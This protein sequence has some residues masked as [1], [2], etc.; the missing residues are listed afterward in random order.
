MKKSEPTGFQVTFLLFAV[1][2]AAM[3]ITSWAAKQIDLPED[4]FNVLGN[5]L[6]FPLEI[7][8][9]LAFA[10]IRGLVVE[11]LSVPLSLHAGK[12]AA[13]V[14]ALK[15][16]ITFGVWG[17]V[18]LWGIHVMEHPELRAYGFLT[19]RDAMDAS[20]LS[21]WGITK[22]LYAVSLGPIIEEILYRGVL[23]RLWERQWGWIA[24]AVLSAAVF[25]II[26]PH[27]LI[28]TFLSA[29]LYA[30]VY[31]R[32]GTLWAPILCHILF[33]LSVTWPLLG[34]V[35]ILKP[36]EAATTFAPWIPNVA[37]LAIGIPG[38][39]YYLWLTART[40]VPR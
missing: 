8:I 27:N 33:N 36:A 40:P 16:T 5:L 11:G 24:G 34:Q 28:V 39:L 17:A 9:V 13:G 31:R 3:L 25:S 1:A 2:F 38:F 12:E 7:G 4:R 18:A 23:Y 26:H 29:I 14:A 10:S 6:A 21:P 35:L 15:L 37:C 20:Y 19:S 30:C 22:A 32:T